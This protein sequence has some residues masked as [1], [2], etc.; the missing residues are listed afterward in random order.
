MLNTIGGCLAHFIFPFNL[1]GYTWGYW[2]TAIT[3]N[4]LAVIALAV[5]GRQAS[6]HP[7]LQRFIGTAYSIAALIYLSYMAVKNYP[8][9]LES[10]SYLRGQ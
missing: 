9:F 2:I 1:N 3:L 4:W 6:L 8:S 7:R 5:I 10:I